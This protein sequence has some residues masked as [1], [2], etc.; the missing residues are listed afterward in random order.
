MDNIVNTITTLF[1][2]RTDRIGVVARGMTMYFKIRMADQE[3]PRYLMRHLK[4][5]QRIGIYNYLPDGTCHW[6][7]VEFEVSE[8]EKA[9]LEKAKLLKKTLAE[10][11]IKTYIERSHSDTGY[12]L[13]TFF[14]RKADATQVRK[15]FKSALLKIKAGEDVKIYPT[16]ETDSAG[17]G[18][19]GD[20][21]WLPFFGGVDMVGKGTRHDQNL[22]FDEN[23]QIVPIDTILNLITANDPSLL[24]EVIKTLPETA[25]PEEEIVIHE[26]K[27]EQQKIYQHN[28]KMERKIEEPPQHQG[29]G[30]DY[31]AIERE[32]EILKG[33]IFYGK[34]MMDLMNYM[35]IKPEHFNCVFEIED[36]LLPLN[37]K[38]Y[39]S[40]K[41]LFTE[42]R[43]VSKATILST[44]EEEDIPID[45]YAKEIDYIQSATTLSLNALKCHLADFRNTYL[46]DRTVE[47]LTEKLILINS[48][49]S[50]PV[51]VQN[52]IIEELL[53]LQKRN[54]IAY[55]MN[56]G[57]I[58]DLV[59]N[60][61]SEN[62]SPIST[63][64]KTLDEPLSGGFQNGKLFEI[65]GENPIDNII[66]SLQIVDQIAQLN[67]TR[68]NPVVILY[69][70]R[71]FDKEELIMKSISRIAEMDENMLESRN[72]KKEDNSDGYIA[73][74][75]SAG[76]VYHS[77]GKW[78][79]MI[80][81][82]EKIKLNRIGTLA[83]QLGYKF[84]TNSV[85]AF[86]EDPRII[87]DEDEDVMLKIQMMAG[88]LKM[89][90][91]VMTNKTSEHNDGITYI[92]MKMNTEKQK[93]ATLMKDKTNPEMV[94]L[95]N[96]K[97]EL[98]ESEHPLLLQVYNGKT[99]FSTV[100]PFLMK[101]NCNQV[102]EL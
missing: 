8:N 5:H 23:S 13:W 65:T 54:F 2:G 88:Q 96:I 92:S 44:I 84:N 57:L 3:I 75:L 73:N 33:L 18:V 53:E 100:V 14:E 64:F 63:G 67:S 90:V 37:R 55:E 61:T 11:G 35:D 70:S 17:E 10:F 77:F 98:K 59:G 29:S 80:K 58:V 66:F 79:M 52:E 26:V 60:L 32:R 9:N 74:I 102:I 42:K 89:P 94:K 16:E 4:G 86:I 24:S 28:G 49:N 47:I 21:V 6:G 50:E 1:K 69:I 12:R 71:R 15:A 85:L 99:G 45:Y 95:K 76:E 81:V 34:D 41:E 43:E 39:N 38:V 22:F 91:V 40:I 51:D 101:K 31:V 27:Q 36:K 56:D 48:R 25:P 83:M 19:F 82:G 97:E 62:T 78:I 87:L 30:I 72:W 68:A 46:R 20:Y 7:V 93:I